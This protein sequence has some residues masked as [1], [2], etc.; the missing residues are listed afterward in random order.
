MGSR[1]QSGDQNLDRLVPLTLRPVC[2]VEG[3]TLFL[4]VAEGSGGD[5]AGTAFIGRRPGGL[6]G[7][8][9][10]LCSRKLDSVIPFLP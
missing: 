5:F 1:G 4:D 6:V 10:V 2:Y 8:V 7:R 9:T 3:V